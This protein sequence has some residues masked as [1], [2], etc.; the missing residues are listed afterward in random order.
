MI[1]NS[2]YAVALYSKL[3]STVD[4]GVLSWHQL[5]LKNQFYLLKTQFYLTKERFQIYVYTFLN[6]FN[7][8]HTRIIQYS[9]C[10]IFETKQMDLRVVS[11]IYMNL[12]C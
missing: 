2:K 4:S 10:H 1:N 11:N 12:F 3:K 7:R 9:P 5:I 8:F 6:H